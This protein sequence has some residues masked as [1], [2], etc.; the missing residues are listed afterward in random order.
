MS[1]TSK[2]RSACA[3]FVGDA[4]RSFVLVV[5]E[6]D[7]GLHVRAVELGEAAQHLEV[8]LARLDL[9]EALAVARAAARTGGAAL[10]PR[11]D[12]L[13]AGQLALDA[14][15]AR[16]LPGRRLDGAL[17]AT[18][19]DISRQ[20]VRGEVLVHELVHRVEGERVRSSRCHVVVL[21]LRF[22][23]LAGDRE[24]RVHDEVDRDDVE[25][26]VGQA[27]E[28]GQL[29][30]AVRDDQRVRDLE[31]VDP[32]RERMLQR[33]PMIEGRTTRG[34]DRRRPSVPPRCARRTPWSACRR[35]SS[36]GSRRG[37]GRSRR[38]ARA[39]TRRGR[40]RRTAR[41]PA[42]PPCRSAPWRA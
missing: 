18:V 42:G 28:L 5:V 30:A 1:C 33:A 9:V 8:V 25:H 19:L 36:R 35:R 24:G 3:A 12:A 27:R 2:P 40:P 11:G 13:L 38:D 31:A 21:R 17:L 41:P 14:Q 4:C 16:E 26:A 37:C 15:A 23:G 34:G 22:G 7:L 39:P 32:A 6:D 10:A 29:A 20:R